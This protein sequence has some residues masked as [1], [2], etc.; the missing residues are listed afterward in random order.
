M[1]IELQP[2]VKS[3]GVPCLAPETRDHCRIHQ[4]YPHTAPLTLH[5]SHMHSF[6]VQLPCKSAQWHR[7]ATAV[8]Q[9]RH[10]ETTPAR[11]AFSSRKSHIE[12]EPETDTSTAKPLE[13]ILGKGV[14]RTLEA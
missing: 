5:T 6:C 7:A 10:S 9:L 1:R 11:V 12:G 13:G 3:A 14:D 2:G 8:S 4:S